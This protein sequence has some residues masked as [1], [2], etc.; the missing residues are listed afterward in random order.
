MVNI[1]PQRVNLSRPIN[2]NQKK[3]NNSPQKPTLQQMNELYGN[4][5]S[6]NI[7]YFPA[8]AM[9]DMLKSRTEAMEKFIKEN[10]LDIDVQN[11]ELFFGHVKEE[12]GNMGGLSGEQAILKML[13]NYID[14][15]YNPNLS[16]NKLNLS[17][18]K[19]SNDADNNGKPVLTFDDIINARAQTDKISELIRNENTAHLK[20][21]INNDIDNSFKFFN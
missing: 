11:L 15:G 12:T 17:F 20:E 18:S 14:N 13:Q 21:I 19:P 7:P 3:E 1:N 9:T 10:N 2:T 4:W 8:S 5:C 6:F 16:Q